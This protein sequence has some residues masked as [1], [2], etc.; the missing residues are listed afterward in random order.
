MGGALA[1]ALGHS[2]ALQILVATVPLAILL[3]VLRLF[4][5]RPSKEGKADPMAALREECG[6][7]EVPEGAFPFAPM[8]VTGFAVALFFGTAVLRW[9]LSLLGVAL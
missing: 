5:I 1:Q 9:Y 7:E 2:L 3:L 8:L 6:E 4:R